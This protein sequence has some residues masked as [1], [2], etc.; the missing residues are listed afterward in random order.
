MQS[1]NPLIPYGWLR[2]ILFFAFFFLVMMAM[3]YGTETLLNL[4]QKAETGTDKTATELSM[5]NVWI[6]VGITSVCSFFSVWVFRVYVDKK[7]VGSLGFAWKGF[8][9]HAWTGFF[10]AIAMLGAGTLLLVAMK[11]LSFV[12]LQLDM[13][14]LGS[15]ILLMLLVAF[16]EEL[17]FRGYLL[18]NLMQSMNK[19]L[20]LIISALLFAFVHIGNPAAMDSGIPVIEVFI[21]GLM[22]GINYVYTKNLWFGIFLHFGWNFFM[23]PVLGYEVSGINLQPILTQNVTGPNL[24]TGGAFGFEGSVLSMVVNVIL[25]LILGSVYERK[26]C[27]WI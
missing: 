25:I 7:T 20:A 11:Y 2:A 10:A 8:E 24:W 17:F 21:G 13:V 15:N 6:Q 1:T 22:L 19:W 14:S 16:A 23:G 27:K 26:D 9:K 18:N 3:Q 5:G 12:D 4:L